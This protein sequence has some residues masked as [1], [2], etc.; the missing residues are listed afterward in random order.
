ML[1]ISESWE[2]EEYF[3]LAKNKKLWKGTFS[4]IAETFEIYMDATSL[5]KY[6]LYFEFYAYWLPRRYFYLPFWTLFYYTK[7]KSIL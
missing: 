7:N 5:I 2:V 4:N 1:F 3:T 6:I